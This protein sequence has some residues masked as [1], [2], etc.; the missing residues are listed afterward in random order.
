MKAQVNV[1]EQ[2][3]RVEELAS[4][5]FDPTPVEHLLST[6][7][8]ILL[9]FAEQTEHIAERMRCFQPLNPDDGG[10]AIGLQA[11]RRGRH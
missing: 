4:L 10:A 5:G 7:A 6:Y 11:Q 9:L 3:V 8:G 1:E 2:A